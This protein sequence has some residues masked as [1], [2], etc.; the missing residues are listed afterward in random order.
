MRELYWK[1]NN[2]GD[3]KRNYE[4]EQKKNAK[5]NSA[6]YAEP[7]RQRVMVTVSQLMSSNGH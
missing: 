7:A 5:S 4:G 6:P 2:A 3:K 1:N